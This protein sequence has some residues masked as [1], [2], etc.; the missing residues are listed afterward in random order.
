[1]TRRDVEDAMADLSDAIDRLRDVTAAMHDGDDDARALHL[2]TARALMDL[3]AV[4]LETHTHE[5]T[6]P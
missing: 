1:M 6:A 3:A 2:E 5:E 4:R